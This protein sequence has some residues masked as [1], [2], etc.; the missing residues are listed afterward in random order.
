MT[1][2]KAAIH[3]KLVCHVQE[4]TMKGNFGASVLILVGIVALA[5]NLGALDINF[6]QLIRTWWPLLLIVLGIGMF[7]TPNGGGKDK[8]G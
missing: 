4:G 1:K 8:P 7:F 3:A 2:N 6:V 5:V